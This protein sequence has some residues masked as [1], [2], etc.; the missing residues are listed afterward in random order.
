MLCSMQA[1]I[2]QYIKY[3]KR[4]PYIYFYAKTV[5]TL[6]KFKITLSSILFLLLI[7]F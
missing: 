7:Y 5:Y 4:Q 3:F 2:R 1:S 6:N